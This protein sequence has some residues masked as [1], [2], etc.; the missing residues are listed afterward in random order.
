MKDVTKET[1]I[2]VKKKR[3]MCF[4]KRG[5]FIL[6]QRMWGDCDKAAAAAG[7]SLSQ[8]GFYM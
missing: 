7:Y 6:W 5:V 4:V 8:M 1:V 2:V 3:K